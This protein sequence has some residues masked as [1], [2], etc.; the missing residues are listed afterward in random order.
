MLLTSVVAFNTIELIYST[1]HSSPSWQ[2][3]YACIGPSTILPPPL[4]LRRHIGALC[5]SIVAECFVS[6]IH[7]HTS[8]SEYLHPCLLHPILNSSQH[9]RSCGSLLAL[10]TAISIR[11]SSYISVANAPTNMVVRKTAF[12]RT[13]V[14]SFSLARPFLALQWLLQC[15]YD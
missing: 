5:P 9:R 2:I 6:S 4:L 1:P 14:L 8:H 15:Q 7:I 13:K 12:L 3:F 10:Q 11:D